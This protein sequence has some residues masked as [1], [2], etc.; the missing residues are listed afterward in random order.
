V[1]ELYEHGN[2]PSG[3]GRRNCTEYLSNYQ[4]FK[5]DYERRSSSHNN[6]ETSILRRL[7]W[8]GGHEARMNKEEHLEE[9]DSDGRIGLRVNVKHGSPFQTG[10]T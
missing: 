8:G 3:L 6:R 4:H 9:Q 10:R 2:G 7:K 5:D 1:A